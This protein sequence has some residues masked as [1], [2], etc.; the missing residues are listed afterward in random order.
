MMNRV[1]SDI[2]DDVTPE[3]RLAE[4]ERRAVQAETALRLNAAKLRMALDV[5]RLGAWQCD[6]ETGEV[7]GTPAFKAYFGLPPDAPLTYDGLRAMFH[8]DDVARI[9]QAVSYALKTRTDFNIEHRIIRADGRPGRIHVRGGVIA[10]NGKPV[11]TLGVVQDI[12][13]RDRAREEITLA[14]RRQEFLLE[15]NDQLGTL[16]DPH[17]IMETAARHLAHFLDIDAASYGEVFEERGDIVVEREWSKGIISNEGKVE[18]FD[19]LAEFELSAL[20]H[21]EPVIVEDVKAD[22]RLRVA[23]HQARYTNMNIRSLVCMP[24]LRN[25]HLKAVLSTSSAAPRVWTGEDVALIE[26]VAERTWLAIE[27]ARAERGL[28]ET[29]TRFGIIAESLPA[30]VWIVDPH[31]SLTYANE[32]WA[33]YSGLP[34]E[35]ALGHSWMQAI[36]P[37]DMARMHEELKSV[38]A[39]RTPYTT[40][41]RYRS[42]TGA[43]RWH[44]IQ[45]E[46]FYKEGEFSGWVGTSVDIHDLKET[47]AALRVSEERLSL[48]QRAAGIGVYD[49]DMVAGKVLWTTEQEHLFGFEPGTFKGDFSG[50]TERVH[51]ADRASVLK[52]M[53]DTESRRD[54]EFNLSYRIVRPDKSVRFIG[55]TSVY[56]YDDNGT[57][58]RLVG[59]NIDITRYKQAEERQHLL[60]RE[61]HHRVKNTLAT[62][63][64]IVGSTARTSSSIDEFYQGFVGRIVSLART[65]NLLT[66]DLWQRADLHQ[67]V[68]TELGPY[69]DE[70][71]NRIL[72]EGPHVDLPSEAA[73][74]IGMAIHELTTNAAKHGA[75]STF[76]GQVEVR[77]SIETDEDGPMLHFAWTENGGPRV[78]TPGRQGF[79]SRLLQRVLSTQL[80]AQVNMDFPEE[81]LHFTMSMP[82]PGAPPLFNPDA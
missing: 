67:L 33:K 57:P 2:T 68:E 23:A 29:E 13:E 28:R 54:T 63:Q 74:P 5:S 45:A 73:V 62:V 35:E 41:V 3:Q 42:H 16:D 26:D 80:Q 18:K 69:E 77:W 36:H 7:T 21:G 71:R 48:A 31:I 30:L 25:D 40:E 24:V 53:E 79:G 1:D 11:Y 50:W 82:I 66:E 51:P 70:A 76:G 46:P 44:L 72:I 78:A 60:I 38:M 6:Q 61:L 9:D 75:L 59:V 49:Y 14:Q 8:P 19:Q 47:E 17:Q 58:T 12:T 55:T 64:A 43:Y 34:P 22:P 15:L 27:K 39:D 81:G 65:H 4:L 37:D 10:Q 32:R 52:T 56:F 20:R